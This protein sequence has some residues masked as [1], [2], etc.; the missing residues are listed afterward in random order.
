MK[1]ITLVPFGGLCNRMRA[2]ASGVFLTRHYDCHIHILWNNS[3]GLKADFQDLFDPIDMDDI[4]ID[5]NKK[6]LY[7]IENT[8]DYLLRYIPLHIVGNKIIFNFDRYTDGDIMP[9]ISPA[10]TEKLMLISC[11]SMSEHYH[12]NELFVPKPDIQEKI[13]NITKNFSPNTIGIHIRRTDNIESIKRS[14]LEAFFPMLD[15]E[16]EKDNH[17]MFFL[18]SDDAETKDI[19]LKKYPN[20]I[21]TYHEEV[22]RNT[23]AGMKAAVADLFA[24]S[25]TNKIIGSDFSSYSNIAAELGDINIEF[26]TK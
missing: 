4:Q 5:E 24:L 10:K 19:L 17:V 7:K 12:L 15:R 8:K 9:L 3:Y 13:D 14:P 18:A 11:C 21:I 23:C 20:R 1:Q 26:A 16:I 25:K 22:S 2:I 6:W